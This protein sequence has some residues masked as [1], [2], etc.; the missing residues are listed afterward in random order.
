MLVLL[1]N[2]LKNISTSFYFYIKEHNKING[3]KIVNSDIFKP[4][5]LGYFKSLN[6][7]PKT[8]LCL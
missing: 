8:Y 6:T 4:I 2:A 7:K 5:K 3:N 1:K